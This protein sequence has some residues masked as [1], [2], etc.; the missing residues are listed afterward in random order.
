MIIL[1][2]PKG[3]TG[4]KVVDG[5]PVEG[6]FRAH[7]VAMANVK[8]DAEHLQRLN[9]WMRSYGV[10]SLFSETGELL[11]DL[12]ALTPP[13]DLRMGAVT[14]VNGGRRLVALDLPNFAGYD[15]MS[16]HAP[17]PIYLYLIIAA[18]LAWSLAVESSP[19]R[20]GTFR[21][22][23]VFNPLAT[24]SGLV[25]APG[26]CDDQNEERTQF[27]PGGRVCR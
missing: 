9:T 27:R 13:A 1:H 22:L 18:D 15:G 5:L 25:S 26:A 17:T 19:G 12:Q 4:S 16:A 7:Q 11:P 10:D 6:T 21:A 14:H 20:L 8:S 24:V 23:R 2:S 3:W